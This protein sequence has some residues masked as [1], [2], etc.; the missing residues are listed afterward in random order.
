MALLI[1]S[2]SVSMEAVDAV[3]L[4]PDCPPTLSPAPTETAVPSPS[5]SEIPTESPAPTVTAFP[6]ARG[7]Y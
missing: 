5:P 3:H 2:L 6:T 1:I 7:K 4:P